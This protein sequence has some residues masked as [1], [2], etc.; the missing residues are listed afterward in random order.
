MLYKRQKK[1]RAFCGFLVLPI[2]VLVFFVLKTPVHALALSPAIKDIV[3]ERGQEYFDALSIKN[4]SP[5][6]KTLYVRVRS[7][8]ATTEGG[9]PVLDPLG[10]EDEAVAWVNLS[11]K[12]IIVP[13]G[14]RKNFIF[15]VRPPQVASTGSH[16]LGLFVSE[17][18]PV[19]SGQQVKVAAEVGSLWSITI[20]GEVILSGRV[21]DFAMSSGAK[22]PFSFE[23]YLL[24]DG[25]ILW[26]PRGFVSIKGLFTVPFVSQ[27]FNIGQR[28]VL[29]K[30]Q[31]RFFETVND[32]LPLVAR[33][34]PW[35]FRATLEVETPQGERVSTSLQWWHFQKSHLITVGVV[36]ALAALWFIRRR[37]HRR[38]KFV[39]KTLK[40]GGATL[41][42]LLALSA[43]VA[44]PAFAQTTVQSNTTVAGVVPDNQPGGIGD[45]TG[46]GGG[47]NPPPQANPPDTAIFQ[48]P[49]E[50]T[51]NPVTTFGFRSVPDGGTFE[52]S[53]DGAGYQMCTSPATYNVVGN[54]RH[55]FGVRAISNGLTDASPAIFFW[56]LDTTAPTVNNVVVT[57]AERSATAVWNS[58]AGS[59]NVM[60]Y[61]VQGG[62]INNGTVVSANQNPAGTFTAIVND[63][64]PNTTYSYSV[65]STDTAGNTAQTPL[66]TFTTL[67]D[68]TPPANPNNFTSTPG[69]RQITLQWANPVDAD[70]LGVRLIR[71][72]GQFPANQNDGV[73]IFSQDTPGVANGSRTD[74]ELTNG[75]QYFYA[76]FAYDTAG[77]FS[78]G[79][80][81]SATPVAPPVIAQC[82]DGIDNDA[83]GATDFPADPD[84][85]NAAD[86]NETFVPVSAPQCNDNRDNDNDNLID[87][88]NDPGCAN[89]AD[90]D[91][92][93]AVVLPVV[94][95][96]SD[97]MDNDNDNLIDFPA[98]AGCDNPNDVNEVD[99]AAPP[100][101]AV[102]QC[103][104]RL[105]NDNDNLI[106]FPNDLGCL[107]A[108]DNAEEDDV[109]PV[110]EPVVSVGGKV[111]LQLSDFT[112][113][114]AARTITAQVDEYGEFNLLPRRT[115]TINTSAATPSKPLRQFIVNFGRD[116]YLVALNAALGQ[117]YVDMV[118]SATPGLT[119]GSIILNY[120]DGS[121]DVVP[122]SVRVHS[123][124]VV[125]AQVEGEAG[126]LEGANILLLLARNG[127]EQP[128]PAAMHG[129]TNP[130]ITDADG[131][132]GFVVQTGLYRLQVSKEGFEERQTLSFQIDN[133][134]VARDMELL[135]T[136]KRFAEIDFKAPTTE[137]ATQVFET[138]KEQAVFQAKQ[139]AQKVVEVGEKAVEL[140]DNPQ[141]EQVTERVVAP[142]TVGVVAVAALPV[143]QLGNII[144]FLRFVFL[145][146][147]FLFGRRKRKGWGVIYN[148]I[149]KAPLDLALVR[150]ID[151]KTGRFVQSRVTDT[152]G[153]YA[154]LASPGQYRIKTRY[155]DFI[156][157]SALL[158]NQ[159]E[160]NKF[161]DLYH[162]ERLEVRAQNTLI[163]ANIPLDPPDAPKRPINLT[164]R[165]FLRRLQSFVA[166]L[167]FILTVVAFVVKPSILI[168]LLLVVHVA[169]Y[170][171]FRRLAIPAPPKSWGIVY[172][173]KTRSPLGRVVARIFDTQYNKLLETQMTDTKGR[174]SFLVGNNK[175][176]V[177]FEKMG[178][179]PAKSSVI[180]VGETK[181]KG[182]VT[183]NV[184]LNPL[185][186]V[187]QRDKR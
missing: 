70:F 20:P 129:Q 121:S 67:Q 87:F 139:A 107:N 175:Y 30:T 86:N 161:I 122:F 38:K 64:T 108:Q 106:D 112:V 166:F 85:N 75:T 185:N 95:Q 25:T 167:G 59:T 14:A 72:Q 156:Y 105:D 150:L 8:S 132:F 127:V 149:T 170:F 173:K 28:A 183:M 15:S 1:S 83:D 21:D 147:V 78:T 84:C 91:E 138:V 104:D 135:A 9:A 140:A 118:S 10:Q 57:P 179:T 60:V 162:G 117:Y 92:T 80:L 55:S 13:A 17:E 77:N 49:P 123:L 19:A 23:T 103:G 61:V 141:V 137:V 171:A 184:G 90:D 142:V 48:V 52:C 44:A 7:F 97:G 46:G 12:S 39:E 2:I 152:Q 11:S 178:Y 187:G 113:L 168:G 145:Q 56:N 116:S 182:S 115:F 148:A 81:Q 160:D 174:Y 172:D 34:I 51:N 120:E 151:V 98:D 131:T 96:C 3:V 33:I 157:P 176:Y 126:P 43:V 41:V 158:K 37:G 89:L 111:K 82:N 45:G 31:Q 130:T 180:D 29:P 71:Q 18:P 93:N 146:P 50:P 136:P 79:V 40:R 114:L 76:L 102:A 155:R 58:E 63:L 154:F 16:F 42:I 125:T 88:P 69:S 22:G 100:P 124:G 65:R 73:V 109:A 119:A 54:A 99:G 144:P 4:D 101:P 53:I 74:T 6:E 169:L 36:V 134:V 32:A 110:D 24:N 165:K 153:R 66:T 62:N 164:V 143:L 186:G 94:A 26:R 159:R 47:T 177:T 27:E 68:V 128:W 181:G 35:R 5:Q 133:N 163:T